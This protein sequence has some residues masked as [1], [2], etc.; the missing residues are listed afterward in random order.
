MKISVIGLGYI[1]LPTSLLL[2]DNGHE[3]FGVDKNESKI[4]DLKNNILPFQEKGVED[5]YE[6]VIKKESF[7]SG[8]TT[9]ESDVYI[10]AVPTPVD[11]GKV[12]LSFV[13]SALE[14]IKPVFRSGDLVILE[15]T[16]GPRDCK[17][18]II[19]QIE[20]WNK[21]FKFAHCS[22]RA[23]PGNTIHEMIHNDRVIGGID[24]ASSELAKAMYLSFVKG[25]IFVTDPTTAAAC[26]VMENTYR[27]VNIALANEFSKIA[28]KI[29]I[30]VWEAIS[31]ANKHPR[32]DILQPGPGVGGHCIPVDPYFFIENTEGSFIEHSLNVNEQ[33][34][35]FIC[36][37]VEKKITELGVNNPVIGILGYSY[38]KNVD[39]IRETPSAKIKKILSEKYKVLVNDI[40]HDPENNIFISVDELLKEA[41]VVVL[42]TD[43]DEYGPINFDNFN[44]IEFVYDTRNLYRKNTK[45]GVN[46]MTKIY[47][48]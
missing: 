12:D 24:D 8:T 10:L 32:V 44:N 37:E 18:K 42:A 35:N 31:L 36:S 13:Y 47:S 7:K 46:S 23:I 41:S 33:M 40:H 15:S 25:N 34:P 43:H 9:V 17:D 29:D 26:K 39:D 21:D 4:F 16:V 27:S 38:K 5:L 14:S 6:S 20:S 2:A 48:L 22:E 19:P 3:V 11:Q 1:G 45:D 28:K 30:D